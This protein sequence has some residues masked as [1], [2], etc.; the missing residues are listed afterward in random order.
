MFSSAPTKTTTATTPTSI[1]TSPLTIEA[2]QSTST[3]L[4]ATKEI[5]V[6]QDST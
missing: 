4:V 3:A 6:Q 1:K 2:E 5:N